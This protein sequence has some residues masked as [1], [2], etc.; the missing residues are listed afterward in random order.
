[1]SKA[2]KSLDWEKQY[3]LSLDPAL[4]RKRRGATAEVAD[5]HGA[6]TM[7]GEFCAYKRWMRERKSPAFKKSI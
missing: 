1:M 3:E 7:C 2:R 4:A 6:C 5:S